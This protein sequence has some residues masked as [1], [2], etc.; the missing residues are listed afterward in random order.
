MDAA[1]SA[2]QKISMATSSPI[3]DRAERLQ[4]YQ[5]VYDYVKFHIGL[6]L[7]TPP[8]LVIVAD[9]LGV[10]KNPWFVGATIVAIV[11]FLASGI[12]AAL[13]MSRWIN[14]KWNTGFLER[15]ESEA[16]SGRRRFWH[17]TVYWIGLAVG[18]VGLV[19]STAVRTSS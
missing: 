17:H 2:V 14:D 16:F 6:Y 3:S 4:Q 8:I 11:T 10:S 13:F 1:C 18:L 12:H 5:L 9:G 7:A 15:F 19:I